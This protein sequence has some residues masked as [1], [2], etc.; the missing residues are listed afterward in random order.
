MATAINKKLDRLRAR[1]ARFAEQEVAVRQDLH[2]SDRFPLDIWQKMGKKRL[3]GMC[4]PKSYGGFGGNYLTMAIAGEAFVAHGHNMGLAVSW[5]IHHAVAR[6]LI[7]GFGD[8]NQK[9]ELLHRMAKGQLTACIAVSEPGTGAHPKHLKTTA[10]SNGDVY[11]LNGEKAFLTNG[12][13]ADLF[14][15]FA[16]TGKDGG[17]KRFTAFI[18][19]KDTPGLTLSRPLELDFLRPSPHCGIK[20]EGCAVPVSVI[21]GEKG[22]AYED[23]VKPFRELEDGLM[24]GPVVGAMTRQ[25][26][27]LIDLIQRQGVSLSDELKERL[28]LFQSLTDSLRIITYEAAAMLDCHERHPEFLSLT[29]ASRT[30]ST[31]AQSLLERLITDAGVERDVALGH[32]THDINRTTQIAKNVSLIKQRKLGEGLLI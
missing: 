32:I 24:M 18:V 23:M 4:L 9:E 2:T 16:Q 29:I 8:E 22:S 14:V 27:I 11:V 21:L 3:L 6:F 20:L 17:R 28:G 10:N 1:V 15:V 31:E 19:P 5:I 30:I 13:I 25:L 7:L 26:G 12:P